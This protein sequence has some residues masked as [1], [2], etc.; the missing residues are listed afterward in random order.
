MRVSID[1]AGRVVIPVEVRTHAGLVAGTVLELRVEGGEIRLTRDVPGPTLV[2][3]N[4]RIVAR[5]R[6]PLAKR[7]AVDLAGLIE[8]ERDRWPR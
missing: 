7:P 3:R 6:V 1:K 2:R 5:P 4:G 8:E